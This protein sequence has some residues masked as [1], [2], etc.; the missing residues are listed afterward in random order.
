MTNFVVQNLNDSGAGSLRNI[1]TAANATAGADTVTFAAGLSGGTLVLT[2]GQLNIT[3]DVTIRG[4]INGDNKADITISGNNASR[5][6]NQTGNLTDLSIQSLTLTNGNAGFLGSGGAIQAVSG[7]LSIADTTIKDSFA[8]AGGGISG[9]LTV[10]DVTNSLLSGNQAEYTGGGISL[11]GTTGFASTINQV[12]LDGNTSNREGG[13]ISLSSSNLNV[14]HSTITNNRAEADGGLTFLGGGIAET[15]SLLRVFGTAMAGNGF[16]TG[17]YA[18]DVFGTINTASNNAFGTAPTITTGTSNFNNVANMRLGPLQDNG[19]TTLTHSI[20]ADSILIDQGSS[21]FNNNFDANGIYRRVGSK[22]DIGATEF[23]LIVTT[24]NDV[25]AND[26]LLSLREAVAMANAN[27]GG[28]SDFDTITFASNLSGST[29]VLTGGE[30]VLTKDVTIIGDVNGDYKADIT[31]SGNNASRI[32]NQSGTGTDVRLN[33]LNLINGNAGAAAGGAIYASGI[34]MTLN[35]LDSTVSNS[36]AGKGGGIASNF[37]PINIANSL[38]ANNVATL[39]TGGGISSGGLVTAV[40]TTIYGNS[41][42]TNGGGIYATVN[43][44]DSSITGNRTKYFGLFVSNQGG[45]IYGSVTAS[46]SIIA[47]NLAGSGSYDVKGFTNA[48]SSVFGTNVVI[49]SGTGNQLNVANVGLG[50]LLDNGGTV[51]TQS[52]LDGSILIGAGNNSFLPV[53]TRDIDHDFNTSETLPL[54][55]RGG[56]RVVGGTVDVGAVEQIV[57]ETIRGTAGVN[58]ILGGLGKDFLDGLGGADFLLGGDGDD[59]IVFDAL[60]VA[61]NVDGGNGTDTL[62][63][64]D[65]AAA[66]ISYNLAAGHFEKARWVQ[67]DLTNTQLWTTIDKTYN[68][69]WQLVS[70]LTTNDIGTTSNILYDYQSNQTWTRITD[71]KDA[72]GILD[73][74]TTVFDNGSSNKQYFDHLS[75]QTWTSISDSFDALNRLT[76]ETTNNDNGTRTSLFL[77]AASTNNWTSILDSFSVA[78]ALVTETI[79]YDDGNRSVQFYDHVPNQTWTSILQNFDGANHLKNETTNYDNGTRQ[80]NYLDYLS[81]QAW[82]N[83]ID[84]FHTNG[85]LKTETTNYDTGAR[86]VYSADY[87]NA[88]SWASI[89]DNYDTLNRLDTELVRNDNLSYSFTDYDQAMT[90]TWASDVLVYNTAQVLTQHYR[91]M[92]NGS[93][94]VL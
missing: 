68:A 61:A 18:S 39:T 74:K 35:L 16:S 21:L 78:N 30:L 13:G 47:G 1:L 37:A 82:A 65:G 45:G 69:A 63:V 7:T 75:N 87:L 9:S 34:N 17:N 89:T 54:D 52:P 79:A 67:H 72:A 66:P 57:D 51:L 27:A 85:A 33:S 25:V 56:L 58:T 70:Q 41:A 29:L 28:F 5:I 53:D 8:G 86:Q 10:V 76:S 93:I 64:N 3:D 71:F 80:V 77:D 90:N 81:N 38:I 32:F 50:Q 83:I 22:I 91:V 60:D 88:N 23:R 92:D 31:I 62:L 24:A 40:N 11:S 59:T 42:F 46:N 36:V 4:D 43:L 12:T 94:V 55:G 6:F 49:N 84:Q 73:S 44:F 48:N 20:V 26:G 15:N 19:G 2:S 14:Y